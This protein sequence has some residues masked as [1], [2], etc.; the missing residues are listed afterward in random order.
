[1]SSGGSFSVVLSEARLVP[2]Y[3]SPCS[4]FYSCRIGRYVVINDDRWRAG[5]PYFPGP[6]AQYRQMVL[7]HE[8]GHWLG[9]GHASCPSR[10]ALAP[11]MQQQ[12]K[13]MQGCA[14]NAWPLTRE[15]TGLR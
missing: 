1:M 4:S 12:S 8:T 13:G 10:G 3:G 6:L 11:V 7:N 15:L 14:P 5:S 9:K 2:S